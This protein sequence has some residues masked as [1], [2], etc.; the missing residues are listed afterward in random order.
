MLERPPHP[1]E[2]RRPRRLQR[3]ERRRLPGAHLIACS[4]LIALAVSTTACVEKSYVVVDVPERTDNSEESDDPNYGND[5]R[6]GA[7]WLERRFRVRVDEQV[8]TDVYLPLADSDR[9]ANGPFPVIVGI[10]GGNV[11]PDAYRW[12]YAH[13]ATRGFVVLAPEH[14]ADLAIASV[15][16][17]SEVLRAARARAETGGG[18]LAGRLDSGRAVAIGHSLGGVVAAKQWLYESDE[19]SRLVLLASYPASGDDFGAGPRPDGDAVLSLVGGDDKRL[20]VDIAEA[21]RRIQPTDA[22]TTFAVID[23]MNHYQWGDLPST[24]QLRQDGPPAVDTETA[25]DRALYL[26]DAFLDDYRGETVPILEA[27]P[28]WPDGLSSYGEWQEADP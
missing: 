22:P 11:S 26:L 27:T 23:G 28:L 5:G 1:L 10:Q 16:N 2:R 12:L 17:G 25:R 14:P 9:L 24:D 19:F 7:A 8:R 4:L 20:T 18:P 6:F 15:G 3:N 13:L 21:Y